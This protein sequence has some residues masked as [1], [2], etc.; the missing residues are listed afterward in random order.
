MPP[1]ELVDRDAPSSA[2]QLVLTEVQRQ[3]Q[4][5]L[6]TYAPLPRSQRPRAEEAAL[7]AELARAITAD[8]LPA[9]RATSTRLARLLAS[10]GM[11][12][13]HA[14]S[15]G[16]RALAL[17]DD[18]T[19]R[20]ELAGWLAGLGEPALAAVELLELASGDAGKVPRTLVKVGVLLARAGDGAGAIRVWREAGEAA[21][22]DSMALELA[23]MAEAWSPDD[24]PKEDAIEAFLEAARRR[25]HAGDAEGALEDRL[26]ALALAELLTLEPQATPETSRARYTQAKKAV[27]SVAGDLFEA[28]RHDAA[29]EVLRAAVARLEPH[30]PELARSL[31]IE[32]LERAS[33]HGDPTRAL[34]AV[35]D[36]KLDVT[37]PPDSPVGGVVDSTLD[38]A[39]LG[40][41]M[42][43]RARRRAAET[44]LTSDMEEETA[45][46]VV[47]PETSPAERARALARLGASRAAAVH[48]VLVVVAA[49]LEEAAGSHELARGH[50]RDAFELEPGSARTA[51]LLADTLPDDVGRGGVGMLEQAVAKL[52]PRRVWCERLASSLAELGEHDLSLAWTQRALALRPGEEDATRALLT[53]ALRSSSARTLVE[54]ASWVLAQPRPLASYA[55]EVLAVLRRALEL[56]PSSFSALA[57]RVLDV[58]GPRSLEVRP[59]L[60]ALAEQAGDLPL[61]V[62][63][64]ERWAAVEPDEDNTRTLLLDLADLRERAGDRDGAVR[65]LGRVLDL[66]ADAEEIRA[67][68]GTLLDPSHT[69]DSDAELVRAAIVARTAPRTTDEDL[70]LASDAWREL[71]AALF[72]LAGDPDGADEALF[73]ADELLR[74]RSGPEPFSKYPRDLADLFGVADALSRTLGRAL[75]LTEGVGAPPFEGADERA[76][77]ARVLLAGA[78][79][80]RDGNL[81]A[82][83]LELAGRALELDPS[84]ADALALLELSCE[85]EAGHQALAHAYDVLARAALGKYGRRAAHYRGARQL[86][87]R[88]ATALALRHAVASFEAVPTEGQGY[89]QVERLSG[90]VGDPSEAVRALERVAEA[91]SPENRTPW[92]LRAASLTARSLE[93]SRERFRILLRALSSGADALVLRHL[94][95]ATLAIQTYGGSLDEERALFAEAS[96]HIV[97]DPDG[98]DAARACITVAR[99]AVATFGDVAR[100]A[101]ALV[102]AM[103]AD[104]DLE[105]FLALA[106]LVPQIVREEGTVRELL[107]AIEGQAA[108]PYS[109]VGPPLFRLASM[110]AQAL[111]DA[112]LADKLFVEAAAR[113][114]ED[115]ALH[116]EALVRAH[117][118]PALEE[119][120]AKVL[121]AQRRGQLLTRASEQHEAGGSHE[122]ALELAAAA[123]STEPA[124]ARGHA[125][126]ALGLAR[127]L[128]QAGHGQAAAELLSREARRAS[129]ASSAERLGR[130]AAQAQSALGAHG[131][132]LE[133]LAEVASVVE[134]NGALLRELREL[135]RS[136]GDRERLASALEKLAKGTTDEGKRLGLL[137][138][139]AQTLEEL[140]DPAAAV[141]YEAVAA[142]DPADRHALEALEEEAAARGDHR[143]VADLLER[144]LTLSNEP[145]VRR[146][147]RLRR[148]ALLEQRLERPEEARAELEALLSEAPLDGAAARYLADLLERSGEAARAAALLDELLVRAV[149][150]DERAD[151]GLRAARAH[152]RA[153]ALDAAMGALEG[154][155]AFAPREAVLEVRILIARARGDLEAAADELEQ[156]AAASQAPA[157]RRAGYLLEAAAASLEAGHPG[158]AAER[159]H[160]AARLAPSDAHA[161]IEALR[162]EYLVRGSG[163]PRDAQE[164]AAELGRVAAQV[165]E[166]DAA[167]HAFL[168]A[169]ALDAFQ[170]GGAGQRELSLR[171]AE[172]G[173][174][175]PIALG[176]AERLARGGQHASAVPLYRVALRGDLRGLRPRARVALAAGE[177]AIA[178]GLDEDAEELL[179][180]AASAGSELEEDAATRASAERHL[181]DLAERKT[182]S[183]REAL[184]S[185]ADSST[186]LERARLLVELARMTSRSDPA[187]AL[188]TLDLARALAEAD[189]ELTHEI[190]ELSGGLAAEASAASKA[191]A[192]APV[193]ETLE[194]SPSEPDRDEPD[195]DEPSRGDRLTLDGIGPA[196][197][198]DAQL[199][200]RAS[201]LGAEELAQ[202]EQAESDAAS[203]EEI[204]ELSEEHDD[205]S[206]EDDE[207]DEDEDD[208]EDGEDDDDGEDGEDG[209]DD[210]DGEDDERRR[211]RPPPRR[212]ADRER[213][214]SAAPRRQARADRHTLELPSAGRVRAARADGNERERHGATGTRHRRARSRRSGAR[215]GPRARQRRGR[216]AA[217]R[218]PGRRP[219]APRARAPAHPPRAERA[220]PRSSRAAREAAPRGGALGQPG[221]HPR[222]RSRALG[223]HARERRRRASALGAARGAR[224]GVCAA[225]PRSR[226]ARERGAGGRVAD[227]PAQA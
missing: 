188:R 98:P 117:G 204:V 195:R 90:L 221:A 165:R 96:E 219:R 81:V 148:A 175:G 163:T 225:L 47:D 33:A 138:A 186:G 200:V 23:A 82:R 73:I 57:R 202:L 129:D 9:E 58:Y 30:A 160:R 116:A 76:R 174:Q 162:I 120:L 1:P 194:P 6:R 133:L 107:G 169:E 104:G 46:R 92:L 8:D 32:R 28:A 214:S 68:L 17:G 70:A 67:R 11:F 136:S 39:G 43:A 130:A 142:L 45:Q 144:R 86:E 209:E 135:A 51:A 88:G 187:A 113:T 205:R 91:G 29:D 4:E 210:D 134:D 41:L 100:G 36:G 185:L 27:L 24:M 48:A 106:D 170:G 53:R 199:V 224:A 109:N 38:A 159:A 222:H 201:S 145:S 189:A 10:R 54:V 55:A 149:D 179:G 123:L 111:G 141:A 150:A 108:R 208:G 153:G 79:L 173:P 16:Q 87:R 220:P 167:M 164:T 172:L 7:R 127:R 215:R 62:A 49:R 112:A 157:E 61:L 34:A 182:A 139:F 226:L 198:R 102:R 72:D 74:Q 18:P 35:L 71:G 52:T 218:P 132:A 75:R 180:W 110:L 5:A 166:G 191:P 152:A 40:V 15:L 192:P 22:D 128:D 213:P 25:D 137:R 223:L 78:S 99:I 217:R 3:I 66:G 176:L 121:P 227:R 124:E 105:E 207:D 118:K 183:G 151:L 31:S 171:H 12:L 14:V 216:R 125:D 84:R 44:V 178:A 184:A 126:R 37:E 59:V 131:A 122:L 146:S 181:R 13:E 20:A 64:G 65:E 212:R 2:S 197:T 193:D 114:D 60:M 85:G 21:P 196:S 69:L 19:L 147:L 26:R 168:L 155:A 93:G 97:A 50:A 63:I 143:A 95:E 211:R 177:S 161:T 94:A 119:R 206:G 77:A 80:A 203:H 83:A 154:V 89:R 56:E 156:L 101:H 190:D 158:L 42:R 140:G 103:K 115:D